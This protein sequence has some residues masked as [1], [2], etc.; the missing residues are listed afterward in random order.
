MTSISRSIS[1]STG[2]FLSMNPI[3]KATAMAGAV[4]FVVLW[5]SQ[6][7]RTQVGAIYSGIFDLATIFVGFLSTFYVFVA[8]KSNDFL[9]K[10]KRTKTYG[11][12]LRLLKFTI[13]WASFVALGS[14]LLAII[15]PR[16]YEPWSLVHGVVF[17]WLAN[18]FVVAVNFTRCVRQFLTMAEAERD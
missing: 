4:S 15:E 12:V 9:E 5:A 8:T 6:G 1:I 2:T 17:F 18:V 11:M 3:L 10:I 13:L 16:D 7:E 14:Y